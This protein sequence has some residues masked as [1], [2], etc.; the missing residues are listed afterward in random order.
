M[1]LNDTSSPVIVQ[2]SRG[3]LRYTNLVYLKHLM[4]AAVEDNPEIKVSLHLDHCPDRSLISRC[5]RWSPT[6]VTSGS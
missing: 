2:A 5:C 3:A 4:M 6:A 1:G